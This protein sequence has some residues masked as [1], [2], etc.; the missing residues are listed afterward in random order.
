LVGRQIKSAA[1]SSK[2]RHIP[3]MPLGLDNAIR[4]LAFLTSDQGAALSTTPVERSVLATGPLHFVRPS[5]GSAAQQHFQKPTCAT[6]LL[7][8]LPVHETL[9]LRLL[10]AGRSI[11]YPPPP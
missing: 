9:P 11:L 8:F 10:S 4:V 7:T 2:H 1:I 6:S 5:I 3:L